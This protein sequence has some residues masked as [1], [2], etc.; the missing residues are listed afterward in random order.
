MNSVMIRC[1]TSGRAV[2]TEIET[3]PSVFRKLPDIGAHMHCPACGQDHVWRISEAWLAGEPRPA[4]P[5]PV[6]GTKAA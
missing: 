3:E 6:V 2:S 1:P 5:M 4:R